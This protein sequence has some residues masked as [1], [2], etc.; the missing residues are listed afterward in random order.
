MARLTLAQRRNNRR[1]YEQDLHRYLNQLTDENLVSQRNGATSRH[2][3]RAC[4]AVMRYR[5]MEV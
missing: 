4:E 2:R 1:K 3:R 5:G